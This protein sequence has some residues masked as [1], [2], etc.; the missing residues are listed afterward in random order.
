MKK[1]NLVIVGLLLMTVIV[2]SGCT[3]NS[4]S[5]SAP[6]GNQTQKNTPADKYV[7]SDGDGIPDN[8][9]NVL[10]TDPKNADTDGDGIGDKQ[11]NNPYLVDTVPQVSS[12]P[13]GFAIKTVLVENNYDEI[14][15]KDAPDH[16]E[17]ILENLVDTEITNFSVY[18]TIKDVNTSVTQSYEL[19][20]TGFSLQPKETKS[21]H[22]DTQQ[23]SN[24]YQANPNSLYYKS[25]DQLE[26]SVM[27]NATGYQSQISTVK[28]DAGG[29]ELAD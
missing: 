6:A 3:G 20:L 16:L 26:I 25:I 24:H 8:A 2:I 17:I 19:P 13:N 4:P 12:G 28:K 9:E 10:G 14:A 15:K 27:V 18:Y 22:I 29:A 23:G 1:V 7:D 11:D 5:N 21:I